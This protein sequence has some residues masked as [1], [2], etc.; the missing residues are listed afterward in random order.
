MGSRTAVA[1][2]IGR[3]K[4]DQVLLDMRGADPMDELIQ[5]LQ[6]VELGTA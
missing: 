5:A 3:V 2:I 4:D 6:D 1:P